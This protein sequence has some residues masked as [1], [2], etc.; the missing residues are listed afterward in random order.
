MRVGS[1]F[2][3]NTRT[4]RPKASGFFC[5][6]ALYAEAIAKSVV[7]E[8]VG[9]GNAR[10]RAG[11]RCPFR[12][13]ARS[14]PPAWAVAAILAVAI[15]AVYGRALDAPFIFDDSWAI[16][17]N[18]SIRSL[19]PLI[20]TADHRGP[21]NAAPGLPA[22]SRPLVNFS[23]ALNYYFGGLS[24]TAY[25]AVN[26][27]IHFL[28]ALMLWA[29]T[30]RTLQLS[31][32]SGRFDGTAGWLGLAVAVLWALHPLQTEAVIYATQRTELMM[33]FFYLATLY[34]SLQ[35]WTVLVPDPSKLVENQQPAGR[36]YFLCRSAWL[37]LAVISCVCGMASKEVMVSAPLMVL[38]FERTFVAGSLAA[39]LRRSWPLYIGLAMT[40]LLLVGLTMDAP[41]RDSAGFG[42]GV[43]AYAWW[44][45]QT[46]VLLMY[47]KLAVWPWPLMIHYQLPYLT[48]FAQAWMYV[49]PVTLLAVATLVLLWRNRPIGYLLT[50]VFAILSPTSLIPIVAEMAAERRM[51]LAL[52][53]PC[54]LFVVGG[55]WLMSAILRWR[56]ASAKR[57][58]AFR[59][60][61]WQLVCRSRFSPSCFGW[62]VRRGLRPTTTR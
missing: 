41:H 21:L 52:V 17:E 32:F 26:V 19:W 24:P 22:A 59:R 28:S 4:L 25:H 48:T 16:T 18:E 47:L 37:A 50:L 51:Y 29:I 2:D 20:G 44:L 12:T 46:K 8:S 45:T 53:T 10:A 57:P 49:I 40:W 9:S 42:L 58:L 33:A 36:N 39:A 30:R 23:F 11:T 13:Q 55:Y 62:P 54:V 3:R 6:T 56:G 61:S 5:C 60:S 35:Y 15:G 1:R 43:S 27:T 31:Y 7:E 34:C 38:L 14:G